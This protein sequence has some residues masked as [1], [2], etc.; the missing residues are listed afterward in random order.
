M[1]PSHQ[2]DRR[3]IEATRAPT[4]TAMAGATANIFQSNQRMIAC[5][6]SLRS[7][8]PTIAIH[9]NRAPA[10][11]RAKLR[12]APPT[13]A[14]EFPKHGNAFQFYA[15]MPNAR[16]HP[17]PN[18]TIMRGTLMERRVH[19]VVRPALLNRRDD[20]LDLVLCNPR[21]FSYERDRSRIERSLS[22]YDGRKESAGIDC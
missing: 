11:R 17:R 7:T 18:S 1:P 10:M 5:L 16:H 13:R 15:S 3:T 6:F 8:L 4:K 12:S 21:L 19:A 2:P 20:R 14:I 9:A 22:I